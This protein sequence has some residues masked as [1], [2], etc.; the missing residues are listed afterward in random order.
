MKHFVIFQ[1]YGKQIGGR[2]QT[3]VLYYNS[4]FFIQYLHIQSTVGDT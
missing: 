1:G 4:K 3:T 2:S